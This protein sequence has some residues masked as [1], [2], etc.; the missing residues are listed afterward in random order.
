MRRW[1][2][3]GSSMLLFKVEQTQK[4]ELSLLRMLSLV[5]T[6]AHCLLLWIRMTSLTCLSLNILIIR[7]HLISYDRLFSRAHHPA[8]V[9]LTCLRLRSFTTTSLPSLGCVNDSS[10]CCLNK[11][12][13]WQIYKPAWLRGI[14]DKRD[15]MMNAMLLHK[16]DGTMK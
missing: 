7:L 13:E 3:S 1:V 6:A 5:W 8:A 14:M 4:A 10:N 11:G 16:V 9:F 15:M 12:R 2:K